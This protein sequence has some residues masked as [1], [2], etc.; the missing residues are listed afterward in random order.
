LG[1]ERCPA[2]DQARVRPLPAGGQVQ[3]AGQAG[4]RPAGRR[5]GAGVDTEAAFSF[6]DKG[7]W[8]DWLAS[9]ADRC[10]DGVWLRIAKKGGAAQSVSHPDALDVALCHGWIDAQRRR[11]DEKHWLQRF[12]PR[13]AR[14]K[15]SQV[16]RARALE[17]IANGEMQ[18]RGLA[19]VDR[20]RADGRWQAAYEPQAQ[21]RVPADLRQALDENPRADAFFVKLDSRNR[22]AILYRLADAKQ[23]E[24]RARRLATYV[25]MLAEHRTLHP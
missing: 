21:A 3:A 16:N 10:P 17:L 23:P 12:T 9:N 20:A 19:E 14:S 15:W 25:A 11:D 22:Y 2:L 24:T 18:P 5:K 13:R 8:S 4:S 7:A 6:A 1:L